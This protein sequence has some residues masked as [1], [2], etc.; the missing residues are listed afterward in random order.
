MAFRWRAERGALVYAYWIKMSHWDISRKHLE[1]F[2]KQIITYPRTIYYHE[3][4]I[5]QKYRT[6]KI[7][8]LQ[9]GL[10]EFL[11]ENKWNMQLALAP[12]LKVAFY[13]WRIQKGKKA[14]LY[15]DLQREILP[16]TNPWKPVLNRPSRENTWLCCMRT[17][18]RRPTCTSA[19]FAQRL[20][21]S[22]SEKVNILIFYEFKASDRTSFGVSK[23]KRRLRR[24]VWVYTCQN[25]TLLEIT[26]RGFGISIF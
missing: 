5:L 2:I 10:I 26:C 7:W 19:Q 13:F 22:L 20:L 11:H 14:K 21:Y 25:A 23:F 16:I 1:R 17:K 4:L 9:T 12:A 6:Y 15:I 3:T 18:R 24:L 8:K